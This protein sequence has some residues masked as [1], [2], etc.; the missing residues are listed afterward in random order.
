MAN[1]EPSSRSEKLAALLGPSTV[2]DPDE[3]REPFT[4]R[5]KR[6]NKVRLDRFIGQA[7]AD[8]R[9]IGKGELVDIAIE[10][11]LDELEVKPE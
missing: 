8:G 2:P 6:K 11:L 4:T 3:V 7:K 9:T 1:S 10:T 5:I